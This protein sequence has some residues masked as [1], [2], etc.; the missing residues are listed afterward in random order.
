MANKIITIEEWNKQSNELFNNS[1]DVKT[2]QQKLKYK[3][4]KKTAEFE[5]EWVE[6]NLQPLI[7]FFGDVDVWKTIIPN[8]EIY[9]VEKRISSVRNIKKTDNPQAHFSSTHW[10]SRFPTDEDW[11]DPYIEYQV[12]GT[13]QFCQTFAMMYLCNKLPKVTKNINSWVKYYNYTD[14]TLQFIKNNLKKYFPDRTDLL[15]NVNECIKY[16]KRCI[17][18]IELP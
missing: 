2:F 16:S 12:F 13:N 10:T 11:F 3:C 17:N 7:D 9:G 18:C 6:N 15:K 5:Q 1:F 4:N 8:V 14:K